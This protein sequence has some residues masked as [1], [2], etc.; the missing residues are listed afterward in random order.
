MTQASPRPRG[1]S[2]EQATTTFGAHAF[3]WSA[4]WDAA[5]AERAISGAA[6]QGLDF[7]EI[8][9]LD[10]DDFPLQETRALIETYGVAVTTSLGLPADCHLPFNPEGAL[11]FLEGAIELTVA[12]GADT[13]TGALYTHLGTL[14]RKPPSE[15]E[16]AICGR[17]LKKAAYIAGERGVSLGIE[18]INR[19]ETYLNNTAAQVVDLL[20]RIDEPNVFAHLDTYHMNIEEKGF[21]APIELL[22]DRLRYIHLSESDRGTPGTGNVHWDDVFAGLCSIGYRGRLAMESFIA[23]NEA[24]IGATAIWRPIVGDP[25]ALISDGLDFLRGKS[26]E[27]DLLAAP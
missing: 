19:Y 7:V 4:N 25:D 16:I 26:H 10:L 3:V 9:L 27:Y 17:T 14:T 20:D 8:P 13:L 2:A 18:A 22:G 12:L 1:T 24:I 11:R 23:V 21:S 5:G 15:E 6:A